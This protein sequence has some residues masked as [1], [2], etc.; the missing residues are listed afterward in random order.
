MKNILTLLLVGFIAGCATPRFDESIPLPPTIPLPPGP[1]TPGIDPRAMMSPAP[2]RRQ[3]LRAFAASS[4]TVAASSG[5]ADTNSPS[6][7][8]ITKFTAANENGLKSAA[9]RVQW[10]NWPDDQSYAIQKSTNLV[11]WTDVILSAPGGPSE[12]LL[13]DLNQIEFYK[14]KRVFTS[15]P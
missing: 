3:S 11:D 6:Y 13:Y 1:P 8:V 4:E 7:A 2:L 5:T 15:T 9:V 14:I 12:V 10:N